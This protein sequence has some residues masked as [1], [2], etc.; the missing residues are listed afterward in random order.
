MDL[1]EQ[2]NVFFSVVASVCVIVGKCYRDFVK[3]RLCLQY[4]CVY[5]KQSKHCFAAACKIVIERHFKMNS[6]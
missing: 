1:R 6:A 4:A 5:V 2:R 3:Q